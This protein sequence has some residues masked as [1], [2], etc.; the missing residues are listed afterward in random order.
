MTSQREIDLRVSRGRWAMARREP[1]DKASV[2][3]FLTL[4]VCFE[5]FPWK[6]PM[7]WSPDNLP[8]LSLQVST[9]E[10]TKPNPAQGKRPG[11]CSRGGPN[12]Q[13]IFIR[14]DDS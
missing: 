10:L 11:T 13:F 1:R 12:V 2:R 6:K 5:V 7:M 9:H 3:S 4:E 14:S 8:C